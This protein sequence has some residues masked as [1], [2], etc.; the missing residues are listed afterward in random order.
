MENEQ[1]VFTIE[2]EHIVT[3]SLIAG[4]VARRIVAWK[5]EGEMVSRG[6]RIG[7]IRF[8]SRADIL[9]PGDCDVRVTQGDKVR[10]GTSILAS[11]REEDA[12]A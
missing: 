4:L 7:L 2:G 6:E 8:G 9:I 10:G 1:V 12:A 11:W 3:F 5:R